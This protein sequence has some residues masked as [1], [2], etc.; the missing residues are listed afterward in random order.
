M[1]GLSRAVFSG[2]GD[3][4]KSMEGR[5]FFTRPALP[6]MPC[7]DRNELL[8]LLQSGLIQLVGDPGRSAN[9]DA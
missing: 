9:D 3:R 4:N 6:G 7:S 2:P 8:I 1:I 5:D